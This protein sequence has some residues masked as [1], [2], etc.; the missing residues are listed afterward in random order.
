MQNDFLADLARSIPELDAVPGT[1]AP[2]T[3]SPASFI[4]LPAGPDM[5]GRL[6]DPVD[7]ERFALA[8]K[9]VLTLVS[10]KTGTR[11]TYR[12]TAAPDGAAHFVALLNGP[13]NTADYKYL[14]RI[15]RS[16]FWAGRKAPRAGDITADAPS[17][18]AFAWAWRSIVSGSIPGTLEIWHEGRC[19]R[20]NRALTVPTSIK[21][22]FGPEC[23]G[24][25][26]LAGLAE[27]FGQ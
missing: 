22:G 10:V 20:C 11:F 16:I 17:S 2:A 1:Q 27:D 7:V 3:S 12:I 18:K 8:G 21:H 6:T 19:G 24:K 15:A 14:G 5:R 4:C 9:A 13:D 25:L 23:F 26:G